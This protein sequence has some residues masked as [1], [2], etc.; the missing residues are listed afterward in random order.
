[1]RKGAEYEETA[2]E[3]LNKLGY[4][5]VERN[6][7]CRTGEID[8]VAREGDTLVFVEVKGGRSLEFGHPIERF[9]TKKLDRIIRCAYT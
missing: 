8:I 9:D 6:Y 4:L 1:M 7:R 5:I 3:Y 2:S